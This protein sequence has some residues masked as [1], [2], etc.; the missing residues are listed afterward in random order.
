VPVSEVSTLA[1]TQQAR[2]VYDKHKSTQRL[3]L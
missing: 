3:F 2:K 1:S